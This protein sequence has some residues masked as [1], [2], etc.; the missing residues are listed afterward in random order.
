MSEVNLRQADFSKCCV[1]Q[2]HDSSDTSILD[3]VE[4]PVLADIR[5]EKTEPIDFDAAFNMSYGHCNRASSSPQIL[6]HTK[7][8]SVSLQ[9]LTSDLKERV[10]RQVEYWLSD[11]NLK[12]D[13]FILKRMKKGWVQI[14]VLA[15]LKKMK[16]QTKD[17]LFIAEALRS[18]EKLIVNDQNTKVCR[19]IPFVLEEAI[20]A[21]MRTVMAKNLSE[22]ITQEALLDMFSEWGYIEH[23]NI[24]QPRTVHSS[25]N[26]S[27]QEDIDKPKSP[28]AF[29]RY[30]QLESAL[31]ACL[32]SNWRGGINVT[33]QSGLTAE[34]SRKKYNE[35]QEKLY[36]ASPYLTRE[37][38]NTHESSSPPSRRGTANSSEIFSFS[39]SRRETANSS[40]ILNFCNSSKEESIDSSDDDEDCET[41]KHILRLSKGKTSTSP[42][43]SEQIDQHNILN[44]S[45]VAID[46]GSELDNESF[47][48]S[49]FQRAAISSYSSPTQDVCASLTGQKS[50][51]SLKDNTKSTK[52]RRKSKSQKNQKKKTACSRSSSPENWRSSISRDPSLSINFDREPGNR[53]RSSTWTSQQSSHNGNCISPLF[54][55]R[56]PA[57]S[58]S[59][60]ERSSSI[61]RNDLVVGDEL[62]VGFIHNFYGDCGF[63]RPEKKKN[64]KNIYFSSKNVLDFNGLKSGDKVAYKVRHDKKTHEP[65]AYAV[66]RVNTG[67]V[68]PEEGKVDL[69]CPVQRL[70]AKGP[71]GSKGFGA[72]RGQSLSLRRI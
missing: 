25:K 46:N 14:K 57:S 47:V 26:K 5:V 16:R 54:I 3:S 72:G 67:S 13:E 38:M 65:C 29:I 53:Q 66:R 48:Q 51:D 69:R 17:Q 68:C 50:P 15:S 44:S 70:Q 40:E 10:I 33:L 22:D 39:T 37:K 41:L 4:T 23:A 61:S 59:N 6:E 28:Y 43:S 27:K 2:T 34:N 31:D 32:A 7:E 20:C 45:K 58:M 64:G 56:S 62:S 8:N 52:Q 21:E 9:E 11:E 1:S 36:D 18:S 63:I 19:R 42:L 55:D 12:N 49:D 35:L 60:K 24:V 71:D 30:V